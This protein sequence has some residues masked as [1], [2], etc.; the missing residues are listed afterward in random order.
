MDGAVI[1]NA[2]I[3][4]AKIQNLDVDKLTGKTTEFVKSSWNSAYGYVNIEYGQM[5]VRGDSGI[6]F[7]G[8]GY[9][10]ISA[11]NITKNP[12]VL[13][14]IGSFGSNK[15]IA[16]TNVDYLA[17]NLNLWNTGKGYGEFGGDGIA[18]NVSQSN[19]TY[20][21][22]LSWESTLSSGYLG[23]LKGWHFRDYASFDNNLFGPGKEQIG[24]GNINAVPALS[25]GDPLT[26]IAGNNGNLYFYTKNG[27]ISLDDVINNKTRKATFKRT[28]FWK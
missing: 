16:H 9:V 7:F 2:S 15:N 17:I 27:Y 25:I 8:D 22:M 14:D 13:E 19:G 11:M 26:G 28:G 18:F 24:I 3:A 1:K 12:P 20:Q 21:S 10:H 6:T 4:S 5:S 23:W